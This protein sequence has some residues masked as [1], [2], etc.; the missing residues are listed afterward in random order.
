MGKVTPLDLRAPSDICYPFPQ[1]KKS[2]EKGGMHPSPPT[3][4]LP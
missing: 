2:E 3:S 4:P 1:E